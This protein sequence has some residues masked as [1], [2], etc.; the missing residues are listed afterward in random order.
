M[1]PIFPASALMA[2]AS[3]HFFHF[4]PLFPHRPE[5]KVSALPLCFYQQGK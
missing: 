5:E 3:S 1:L 2:P 4:I